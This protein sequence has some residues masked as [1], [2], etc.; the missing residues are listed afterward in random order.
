MKLIDAFWEKRNLGVDTL[1][2]EIEDSDRNISISKIKDNILQCLDK[3]KYQYYVLKFDTSNSD[4]YKISS[5]LG[6]HF[7]EVQ[8]DFAIYKNKFSKEDYSKIIR[9]NQL[10]VNEYCDAEHFDFIISKINEGIFSTDRIALDPCFGVNIAN[11]R[12]SNW[13]KDL[14][15][16]KDYSIY[17]ANYNE[18]PIGFSINKYKDKECFGLLGGLFK[19]HQTSGLGVFLHYV[20]LI[21][22]FENYNVMRTSLSSNNTKVIKLWQYFSAEMLKMKYVYIKHK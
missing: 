7:A 11:K 10:K 13:V 4:L 16:N 9:F 20:D 12:Y 6:F 14:K 17:I 8:F 21:K 2:I 22:V 15:G 1:E 19:E 18:I 3:N 5:E